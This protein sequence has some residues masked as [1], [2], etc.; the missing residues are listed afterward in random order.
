MFIYSLFQIQTLSGFVCIILLSVSFQSNKK[1]SDRNGLFIKKR[2]EKKCFRCSGFGIT[3]CSLC[4]GKGFVFYER[5][6]LRSDPCPKCLQRRYD[7]CPFCR[8]IG[9]RIIY[10]R[11]SLKN[12]FLKVIRFLDLNN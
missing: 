10:G 6:Y 9:E 5:K 11:S 1:F 8:G 2:P 3:R 4:K 12:Y 7:I